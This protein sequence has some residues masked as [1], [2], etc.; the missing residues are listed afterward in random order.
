MEEI[1]CAKKEFGRERISIFV[2]EEIFGI[3]SHWVN[4]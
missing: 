3:K 2:M 1:N 4:Y